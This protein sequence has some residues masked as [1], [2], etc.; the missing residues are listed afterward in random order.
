MIRGT[1]HYRIL[2]NIL[3]QFL[4][5]GK[6]VSLVGRLNRCM[7]VPYMIKK[8]DFKMILIP[9]E[10]IHFQKQS[11]WLYYKLRYGHLRLVF[12]LWFT[13]T[14][15]LGMDTKMW[16][17]MEKLSSIIDYVNQPLD[18]RLIVLLQINDNNNNYNV[19]IVQ[20]VKPSQSN[21][22]KDI[23]W[24]WR[25]YPHPFKLFTQDRQW[26]SLFYFIYFLDLVNGSAKKHQ[27]LQKV[28]EHKE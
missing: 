21:I 9:K 24:L 15:I 27:T 6:R 12:N 4:Y 17:I 20:L 28:R 1:I 5:M 8:V 2:K 13:L 23:E 16:M 26:N 22:W 11:N 19:L 25:S 14:V 10:L 7:P 18:N 3:S